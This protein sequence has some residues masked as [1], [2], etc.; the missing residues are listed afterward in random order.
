METLHSHHKVCAEEGRGGQGEGTSI[1]IG[2][3]E[4]SELKEAKT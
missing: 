1:A 4:L 2:S 3:L